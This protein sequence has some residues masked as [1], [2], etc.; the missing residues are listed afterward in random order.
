MTECV[1][2][3]IHVHIDGSRVYVGDFNGGFHVLDTES[4]ALLWNASANGAIKGLP[5]GKP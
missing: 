1:Y 3:C 4:G 2:T 5:T